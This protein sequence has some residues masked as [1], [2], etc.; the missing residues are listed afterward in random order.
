MFIQLTATITRLVTYNWDLKSG[1]IHA[2]SIGYISADH[3]ELGILFLT[4][5]CIYII[6][7]IYI[8]YNIYIIYIYII[9]YIV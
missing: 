5:Q 7:I 6:Y 3:H 8:I 9:I 1:V 2:E 4:N